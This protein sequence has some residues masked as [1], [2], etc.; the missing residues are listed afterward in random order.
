MIQVLLESTECLRGEWKTTVQNLD[1][2][3]LGHW[4]LFETIR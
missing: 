1:L 4:Y 2:S 3:R